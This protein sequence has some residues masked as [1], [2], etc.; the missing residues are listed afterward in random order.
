MRTDCCGPLKLL[1][2]GAQRLAQDSLE[3]S[4]PLVAENEVGTV[5]IAFNSAMQRLAEQRNA[6]RKEVSDRV[7]AEHELHQIYG[8]SHRRAAELDAVIESLPEAVY[9]GTAH[10]VTKCNGKAM[11]LLKVSSLGELT[12]LHVKHELMDA[13]TRQPLLLKQIPFHRALLGETLVTDLVLSQRDTKQE[14]V[15]RVAAAPVLQAEKIVG[16]VSVAT[17]VTVEKFEQEKLRRAKAEAEEANRAKDH[18]LAVLSHELRTP[19]H[20]GAHDCP[21]AGARSG[22]GRRNASGRHHDSAERRA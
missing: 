18:F 9:I 14:I 6:L 11:A 16:A 15:I 12:D 19:A 7:H 2:A 13:Q 17:D 20:A 5:T 21:D 1:L 10:G 22:F 4:V 3:E 8:L